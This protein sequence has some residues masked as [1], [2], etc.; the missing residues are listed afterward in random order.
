MVGLRMLIEVLILVPAIATLTL[1]I[2]R[3]GAGRWIR[4]LLAD[5]PLLGELVNCHFCTSF[6]VSLA[7]WGAFI[8]DGNP[9]LWALTATAFAAPAML[10]VWWPISLLGGVDAHEE[11]AHVHEDRQ[12]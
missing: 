2:T 11:E 8:R 6:W 3:S 1:G 4:K 12:A 5:V 7:C 10:F 9:V